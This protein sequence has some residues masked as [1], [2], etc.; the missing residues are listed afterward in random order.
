MSIDNLAAKR[1]SHSLEVILV[2]LKN[3][4]ESVDSEVHGH[5]N[6]HTEAHGGPDTHHANHKLIVSPRWVN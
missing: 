3:A 2:K 5:E 1:D 4:L 6:G